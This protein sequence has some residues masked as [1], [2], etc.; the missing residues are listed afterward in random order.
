LNRH[1]VD[2]VEEF[3]KLEGQLK[4][5]SDVVLLIARRDGRSFSTLF[6]ADR[7]P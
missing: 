4:S 5:G 6:L 7:L 2:S 1:P 3:N